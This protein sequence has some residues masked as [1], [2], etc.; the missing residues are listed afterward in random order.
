[1]RRVDLTYWSVSLDGVLQRSIELGCRHEPL[2]A[3]VGLEAY[4]LHVWRQLECH[5]HVAP[6]LGEG[7]CLFL[8]IQEAAYDVSFLV[9][10]SIVLKFSIEALLACGAIAE[11]FLVDAQLELGK[12][13]TPAHSQQTLYDLDF[14]HV[15]A[16][17]HL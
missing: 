16:L 9:N 12:A 7:H 1:V 15:T 13:S 10:L 14:E 11:T 4:A 3:N 2:A 6:V 5:P 8:A 17:Q